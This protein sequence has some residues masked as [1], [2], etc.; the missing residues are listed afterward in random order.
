MTCEKYK[1]GKSTGHWKHGTG[2]Q[3]GQSKHRGQGCSKKEGTDVRKTV[4]G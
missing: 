1:K 4:E 3:R 2:A